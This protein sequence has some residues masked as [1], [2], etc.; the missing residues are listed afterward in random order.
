MNSEMA[1]CIAISCGPIDLI[2]LTATKLYQQFT[3]FFFFKFVLFITD[4][5]FYKFHGD[6]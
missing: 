2:N 4:I 5:Q 3:F 1:Y 6:D